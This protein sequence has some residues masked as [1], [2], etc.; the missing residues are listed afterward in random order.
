MNGYKINYF[1]TQ[2]SYE[3]KIL[4]AI[5]KERKSLKLILEG[6]YLV[7]IM[8]IADFFLFLTFVIVKYLSFY[9]AN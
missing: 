7:T 3:T 2:F 6:Y 1:I 4:K 8:F 9:F 5:G